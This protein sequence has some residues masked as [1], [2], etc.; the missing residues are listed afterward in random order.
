MKKVVRLVF[1]YGKYTPALSFLAISF[2]LQALLILQFLPQF[3]SYSGGLKNPDQLF[4]Y[5][6]SYIENLYQALGTEGREFYH[7]MLLVD[8]PYT[9]SAAIGYSLLLAALVKKEVCFIALP[10]L[11]GGLDLGENLCQM[12]LMSQFPSV[13][14]FLV[15]VSSTFSG[16]KLSLSIVCLLLILFYA[17]KRVYGWLLERTGRI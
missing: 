3:L 8:F 15:D 12:A 9:L 6:P 16:L 7:L 11:L 17:V 4:S 1:K 10:L 14:P 2:G 13:S 5:S